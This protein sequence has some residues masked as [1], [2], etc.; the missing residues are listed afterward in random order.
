MLLSRPDTETTILRAKGQLYVEQGIYYSN[1]Y[2]LKSINK[3][4]EPIAVTFKIKEFP[5]AK[6]RMV[7]ADLSL[8]PQGLAQGA[9]FIDIP[10]V[11]YRAPGIPISIEVYAQGKKVETITTRFTGPNQ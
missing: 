5:S 4:F 7:G 9:M 8:S 6:I 1:L 2:T 11:H 3:T 10:K